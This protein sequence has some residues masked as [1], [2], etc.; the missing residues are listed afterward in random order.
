MKKSNKMTNANGESSNPYSPYD[1]K[2][3]LLNAPMDEPTHA[4]IGRYEYKKKN[5]IIHL[6]VYLY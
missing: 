2:A 5:H 4:C 1:L 3:W 6:L